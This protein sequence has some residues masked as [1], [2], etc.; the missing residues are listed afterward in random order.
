MNKAKNTP[1]DWSE[2]RLQQE[3][4]MFHWNG[5]P[6][7]RG[8][9]FSCP[10]GIPIRDQKGKHNHALAKRFK[11]EGLTAGVS[12]LILLEKGKVYFIELKKPDGKNGQSAGQKAWE[13]TVTEDGFPYY[14]L[15]DLL[16]FKELIISICGRPNSKKFAV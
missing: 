9:L 13:K 7:K 14:I 2:S 10:N 12:D 11:S 5:Y 4:F 15:N 8:K 1:N 6:T 3:C 16:V